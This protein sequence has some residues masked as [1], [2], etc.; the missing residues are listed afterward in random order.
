MTP[1]LAA[2]APTYGPL[3]AQCQAGVPAPGAPSRDLD[4]GISSAVNLV[5]DGSSRYRALETATGVPWWFVG[6]LHLLEC[7]C[8]FRRHLYNG[9]PLT[10]RT[11][12][13]PA[14]RPETGEP[15]FTWEDSATDAF[16]N[17]CWLPDRVNR[18]ADGTADWTLPTCLW[19]FEA[20]NGFGYRGHGIRSPY[21]WAGSDLEQPGRYAADGQWSPTTWSKQIGA[22]VVLKA[23]VGRGLV[24]VAGA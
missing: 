12:N 8:N 7:S 4:T 21:L 6:V 5:L 22:A 20:W 14:G 17:H 10:A 18:L 23:M 19:R 16:Q 15:P 1:S 3:W 2:L 11:V 24:Q 13:V 9:D